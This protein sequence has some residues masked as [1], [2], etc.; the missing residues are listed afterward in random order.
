MDG[1]YVSPEMV[2]MVTECE[3]MLCTSTQYHEGTMQP[4]ER[5]EFNW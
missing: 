2:V 5:E 3:G 4:V 1:I